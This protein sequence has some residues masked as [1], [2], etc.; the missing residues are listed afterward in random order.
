MLTTPTSERSID[1]RY[2]TLESRLSKVEEEQSA[3]REIMAKQANLVSTSKGEI[4][5]SS[6]MQPYG[7]FPLSIRKIYFTIRK[8]I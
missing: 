6:S 3:S 1:A 5:G 2:S 4:N 7:H 8:C